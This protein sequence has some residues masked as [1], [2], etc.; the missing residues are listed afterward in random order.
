MFIQC[1]FQNL[2]EETITLKRSFTAVRQQA[3]DL[4]NKASDQGID[5]THLNDEVN[6]I[7]DRIEDLQAKLD[8]RCNELQ[9]AATAVAQF[10]D[11]LRNFTQELV[12]LEK[13]LDTMNS[14]GRDIRI[15]RDQIEENRELIT[16]SIKLTDE[17]EKLVNSCENLVDSGFATDAVATREQVDLLK[18][19]L[20]K[21]E[22]RVYSREEELNH[23][24]NKLQLFCQIHS[25]VMDD[26]N[27]VHEQLKKFK[28]IG[29]DVDSIRVQQDDFRILKVERIEPINHSVDDCNS[30]GQTL[31]QTAGRDVCTSN[32]EK[33]LDKMNEKWNDLKERVSKRK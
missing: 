8:D 3:M 27:N 30:I 20:G 13:A 17:V 7:I 14:S 32:I 25:N 29:S 24:L 21:F 12:S 1:I 23:I 33:N 15:V 16:K 18:R 4:V 22:K 9:S 28:P 11:A 10:T 26:I 31:I 5:A 6:C 2:R 19:Q